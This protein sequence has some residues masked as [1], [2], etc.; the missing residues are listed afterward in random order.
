MSDQGSIGPP[1]GLSNGNQ[2]PHETFGYQGAVYDIV[3]LLEDIIHSIAV[4][5][6]S[7]EAE[8][9]SF[10]AMVLTFLSWIAIFATFPVSVF[11]CFKVR[12]FATG[13]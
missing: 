11:M 7:D 10:C 9:M 5:R 13:L 12:L 8:G 6:G 2:R 3:L 1:Q 4:Q